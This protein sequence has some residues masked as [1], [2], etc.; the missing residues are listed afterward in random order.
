MKELQDILMDNGVFLFRI[1]IAALC[2]AVVGM[3]R[4]RRGR[5]AGL[6]THMII[7][8]S[9]CLMMI[10]SKYGFSDINIAGAESL[11]VDASRIAAGVVASIGFLGIGV[12]TVRRGEVIGLTTAA[13][14][15]LMV[16]IGM[17]IGAG[18]Y[19]LGIAVTL[20][21]FVLQFFHHHTENAGYFTMILTMDDIGELTELTKD[22]ESEGVIVNGIEKTERE[23]GICLV[24]LNIGFAGDFNMNRNVEFLKKHKEVIYMDGLEDI[25][26]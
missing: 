2:G 1:L 22:Y 14:L 9:G 8:I 6:R 25:H 7:A 18:M 10:I 13:G 19:V 11:K 12:I 23:E 3:E 21:E 26:A 4:E 24:T 5:S 16:A 20:F 15:L 17:G